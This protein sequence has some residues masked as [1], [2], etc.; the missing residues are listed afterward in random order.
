MKVINEQIIELELFIEKI[1]NHIEKA[2]LI[3]KNYT[4]IATDILKKY[5]KFNL[6][7]NFKNYQVIKT[8]EYLEESNNQISSGLK[9][10]LEKQ[11]NFENWGKICGKLIKMYKNDIKDFTKNEKDE[12]KK[13]KEKHILST[14]LD[15]DEEEPNPAPDKKGTNVRSI[16]N[17]HE[18]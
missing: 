10:M 4:K 3:F 6:K 8:I 12:N 11:S 5:E 2:L 13:E 9:N 17:T 7:T 1:I 14:N 18:S 16:K 15:E